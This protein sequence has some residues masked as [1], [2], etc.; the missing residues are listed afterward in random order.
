[1][2]QI[3]R[4]KVSRTQVKVALIGLA[5]GLL[6]SWRFAVDPRTGRVDG[7]YFTLFAVLTVLLAWF[8]ARRVKHPTLFPLILAVSVFLVAGRPTGQ[9]KS[10]GGQYGASLADMLAPVVNDTLHAAWVPIQSWLR[11]HG[12]PV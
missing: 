11:S 6:G 1:M 9:G 12:A 7:K 2:P 8:G 4:P 10:I 5:I 3:K